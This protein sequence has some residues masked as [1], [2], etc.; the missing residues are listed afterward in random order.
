[1][2]ITLKYCFTILLTAN[3]SACEL[4]VDIASNN[5]TKTIE[6][7]IKKPIEKIILNSDM[8][9]ELLESDENKIE[10]SGAKDLID[11]I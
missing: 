8:D 10:I 9:L 6:H 4:W 2:K 3:L 7:A 1:M 5:E 11:N